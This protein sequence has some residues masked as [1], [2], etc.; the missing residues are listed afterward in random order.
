MTKS[1]RVDVLVV[2]ARCAGAFLAAHLRQ[3]KKSVIVVDGCTMPSDQ[4]LSTHVISSHGMVLLDELGIGDKVRAIAPP[5]PRFLNGVDDVIADIEFPAG[6]EG[7]CPR[8]LDLDPLLVNEAR[9]AGAD[10]RLRTKLVDLLREGG[11]VIGGIVESDGRRYE[12]R[13]DVVVGAD[14][15]SSTVAEKVGAAEYYAG[16]MPRAAYWAYWKRPADYATDPRYRGGAA[17]IHR[18][19]DYFVVFPTNTDQILVG[20]VFPRERIDSFRGRHKE[21]LFRRL[22]AEPITA[23]LAEGEPISDV[24]GILKMREFFREAAG[25]GWAL[26]GDAS[27]HKDPAPGF[28]ITDALRD[29]KALAESIDAGTDEALQVYWRERDVNALELFFF[30]R[31][32][33]SLDYN[34]A[35]NKVVFRKL[36]ERKDLRDRIIRVQRREISPFAV[37]SMKEIVRWTAGALLRGNIGVIR[38]F[39]DAGKRGKAVAAELAMRK[40]LADEARRAAANASEKIPAR[41]SDSKEA[42]A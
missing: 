24:V 17:I 30:A 21:E 1:E 4:P 6:Q 33:G 8:R 37:F 28:G 10:V 12:I 35:L 31:N 22:R 42:A 7:S 27:L 16:E 34:S 2:G 13:A 20:V 15:R 11:R 3:K 41:P 40:R 26:V 36:S 14:G 25:P 38:P 19:E 29:A 23:P 32:L 18:G 9:A 39:L 5:L